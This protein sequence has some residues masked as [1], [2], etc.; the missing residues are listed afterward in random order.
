MRTLAIDVGNTRTKAALFEDGELKSCVVCDDGNL[1][2]ADHSIVSLTGER[3]QWLPS[4][5]LE[6]NANLNLPIK[7]AYATPATLGH[8]RI[9]TAS[10][11]WIEYRRAV[12]VVDAGTCI[13]VDFVNKDGVYLGGAI[14]PGLDMKFRALHNFTA[15]LPLLNIGDAI[16]DANPLGNSTHNSIVSGVLCATRFALEGYERRLSDIAGGKIEVV[17][18][19][20]NAPLLAGNWDLKPNLLMYGMNTI[21][22][23]NIS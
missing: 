14:M 6:L 20:G 21:L 4:N 7:L 1:P 13:T 2:S 10:E 19:G 22:M 18:T 23:M 16:S 3:P 5:C 11:A 15:H 17:V 9:A 8:D 12:M